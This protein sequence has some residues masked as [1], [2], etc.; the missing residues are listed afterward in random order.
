MC[1]VDRLRPPADLDVRNNS[2][3]R[4]DLAHMQRY[5]PVSSLCSFVGI[6][7]DPRTV[8]LPG[9]ADRREKTREAAMKAHAKLKKDEL[10]AKVARRSLGPAICRTC[11]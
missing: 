9:L 4:R 7:V 11:L 10:A 3:K 2:A 6:V 5:S 8:S 1:C